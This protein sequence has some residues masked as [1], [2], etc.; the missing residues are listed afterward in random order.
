[1]P[2][3]FMPSNTKAS[4]KTKKKKKVTNVSLTEALVWASFL[5]RISKE[6]IF[7]FLFLSVE[8]KGTHRELHQEKESPIG[9]LEPPQA[10]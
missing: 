4:V 10:V 3:A 2:G 5:K 6:F 7:Y 1:M 8:R 9:S